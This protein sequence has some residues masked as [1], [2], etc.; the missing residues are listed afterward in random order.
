VTEQA[1][2]PFQVFQ[3]EPNHIE[4][5]KTLGFLTRSD[6]SNLSW[7]VVAGENNLHAHTG[8]DEIWFVLEGES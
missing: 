3:T 2:A 5:G 6:I 4:Q 8:S 7:Q 1:T